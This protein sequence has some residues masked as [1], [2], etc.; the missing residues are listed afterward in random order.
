VKDVRKDAGMS[1]VT[2]AILAYRERG[3]TQVLPRINAFF[4]DDYA[5][6]T[7]H[8]A[9][10]FVHVEDARLP[11]HWYGGAKMLERDLAI[12]AFNHLDLDALVSHLCSL[13]TP[14]DEDMQLIVKEQEDSRFRIINIADEV[15]KRAGET[16]S[17]PE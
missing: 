2:N 10:G 14:D 7:G 3:R 17:L 1:V 5:A 13:W 6:G 16:S 12:G 8:N 4:V 15:R 9:T 11:R